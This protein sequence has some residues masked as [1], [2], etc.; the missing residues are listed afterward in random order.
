MKADG[1]IMIADIFHTG[2]YRQ[3]FSS[4]PKTTVERRRLGWRFWYGGPHAA[5]TAVKVRHSR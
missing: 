5:T 1:T 4:Q 2:Q 3:Y